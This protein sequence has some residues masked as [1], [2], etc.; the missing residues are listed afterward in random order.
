MMGVKLEI[1]KRWQP[2]SVW[3]LYAI[4]LVPAVSQFYLGAT[5]RL[6]P[7]PVKTFELALGL[8]TLR[9]LILTLAISPLREL[10]GWNL[11]RYRRALG[12]L[13]FYYAVMHF[14]VYMI[15][16]QALY[17]KAVVQDVLKRPFIMFGMAA[18]VLLIP[19]AL[20]SNTYS[21]RRLG[22]NWNRL[23]RLV[24]IIAAL[25]I[26]HFALSTKVL[27]VE[28]YVYLTII[29]GL[30]L[31]R[32]ARPIIREFKGG[33]ARLRPAVVRQSVK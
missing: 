12:L 3:M 24:Y 29:I 23:H 6:G 14:S 25:G 4:G 33:R 11:I 9:F 13:T 27:T 17:L 28:Q 8:W 5:G 1:P 19:L 30:L 16:D 32:S 15:L 18:L 10:G 31:Y 7:D 2:A 26:I 21:I 20:T 22:M